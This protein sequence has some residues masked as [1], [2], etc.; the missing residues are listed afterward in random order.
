MPYTLTYHEPDRIYRKDPDENDTWTI[1]WANWLRG[2]TIS[3]SAWYE[4]EDTPNITV[5][6]SNTTTTTTATISGGYHHNK[7]VL[8]NQITTAAGR[9]KEKKL[10]IEVIDT[11]KRLFCN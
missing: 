7:Y 1:D 4:N 9:I 5:S 11:E 10:I 3:S 6:G 8:T 2:D